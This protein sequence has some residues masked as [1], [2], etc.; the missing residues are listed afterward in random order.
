MPEVNIFEDRLDL[1]KRLFEIDN[2]G[3]LINKY[4]TLTTVMFKPKL[5]NY[6]IVVNM[7]NR[8]GVILR[9]KCEELKLT[10]EVMNIIDK[11]CVTSKRFDGM[12]VEV[13]F[14]AMKTKPNNK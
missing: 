9:F 7:E 14:S 5:L 6:G 1:I 4:N 3:E 13:Q 11:L 8:I 10:K 12:K 2:T